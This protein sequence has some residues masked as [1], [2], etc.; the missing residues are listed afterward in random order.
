MN[1]KIIE[2]YALIM[3]GVFIGYNFILS[4]LKIGGL[5]YEIFMVAVIVINGIILIKFRKDIKYNNW[6]IIGYFFTLVFSKNTLQCY[7]ALSNIFILC[8]TGFMKSNFTKVITFLIGLF[9]I[10]FYLPLC[11][12]FL[13]IF[14]TEFNNERGDNEVY[15]DTH[16]YCQNHYEVYAYSSGAM[17]HYH[18]SI[19]KRY[20]ILN[21]DD[22]I[23]ISYRERN[24]KS[25][26]E[27][28]EYLNNYECTLVG[29]INGSK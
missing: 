11:F 7:L 24:E 19:G 23:Y 26:E 2:N 3:L 8:I 12:V 27:Y 20:D 28:Q 25:R 5:L 29:E 1:K 22:I 18:Y 16:Y 14:G 21:I 15:K 6:V 10:T 4:N 9:V 17:D 13:W